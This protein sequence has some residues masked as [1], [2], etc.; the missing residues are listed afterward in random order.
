LELTAWPV[1]RALTEA[2]LHIRPGIRQ[3]MLW[4]R[5]SSKLES[6]AAQ[7]QARGIATTLVADLNEAVGRADIV[8]SA[9]ATSV[10]LIKGQ[11]V[12]PGTHVDLVG[13]SRPDMQKADTASVTR[14]RL[15]LDDREGALNSGDLNIPLLAGLIREEAILGDLFESCQSSAV[16]RGPEDITLY[17]NA[18][19]AH[20]DLTIRQYVM[21][22]LASKASR[23]FDGSAQ[24]WI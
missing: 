3:V 13:S 24:V 9:T 5:T 21:Q 11:L 18:G 12:R 23:L 2:Y 15:Y 4:N 7:L 6:F 17:E 19:S 22:C 20:L 8:V 10:P 1:A 16:L 14:A